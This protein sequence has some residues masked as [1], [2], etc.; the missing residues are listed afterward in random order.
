MERPSGGGV[1]GSGCAS[2]VLICRNCLTMS[3]TTVPSSLCTEKGDVYC[4]ILWLGSYY[5]MFI[6]TYKVN[7][8]IDDS[9]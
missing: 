5:I 2:I 7:I 9:N 3:S 8:L 4:T 6:E 1:G